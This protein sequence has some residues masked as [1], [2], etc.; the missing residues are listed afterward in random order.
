MY[1]LYAFGL[2]AGIL[3]YFVMTYMD[4]QDLKKAEKG[5]RS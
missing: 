4:E 1:G 5:H 2:I 3:L